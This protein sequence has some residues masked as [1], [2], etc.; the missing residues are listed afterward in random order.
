MIFNCGPTRAQKRKRLLD[1]HDYF[2]WT[3]TRVGDK[4]VWLEIIQ[5]IAIIKGPLF[6]SWAYWEYRLKPSESTQTNSTGPL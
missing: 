3:P 1:W 4:C 6:D 2:A 5:R